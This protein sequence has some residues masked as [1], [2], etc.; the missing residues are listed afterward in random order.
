MYMLACRKGWFRKNHF[1]F[2]VVIFLFILLLS[3]RILCSPSANKIDKRPIWTTEGFGMLPSSPPALKELLLDRLSKGTL[4]EIQIPDKDVQREDCDE[5]C[6]STQCTVMREQQR[7]LNACRECHKD[8]KKCFR[9]T[10]SG[11]NCEDCLEGESQIACNSVHHFGCMNP[12]DIYS[13]EGVDPY[14]MVKTTF[15]QDVGMNQ[16]CVFCHQREDLL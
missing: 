14:Y 3:S 7:N 8:F 5:K 1:W 6:G 16:E 2:V 4:T 11:G 9:P 10:V 15:S 13:Y 12:K